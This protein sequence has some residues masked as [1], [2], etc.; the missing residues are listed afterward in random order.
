VQ[1]R[2]EPAKKGNW[3]GEYGTKEQELRLLCGTNKL[4]WST[5]RKKEQSRKTGFLTKP[6]KVE[7]SETKELR[8]S[9]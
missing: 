2:L 3:K 4:G 5:A 7:A 9:L 6:T 8:L 1:K